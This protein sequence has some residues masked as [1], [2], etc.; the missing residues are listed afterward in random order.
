MNKRT[1][2]IEDCGRVFSGHNLCSMHLRRLKKHGTTDK[3]I[4]VRDAT[5]AVEDCEGGLYGHG[6]CQKHWRRWRK[7][8]T[9]ELPKRELIKDSPCSVEGCSKMNFAARL[10]SAHWTRKYRHGDPEARLRGEVR[11]GKRICSQCGIDTPLEKMGRK[12]ADSWCLACTASYHYGR[13][14]YKPKVT[15][16]GSCL[17]CGQ[18]FPTNKKKRLHC[19]SE[20]A[21][22]TI[23]SRNWKHL[24]RRRARLKGATTESFSRLEIFERDNWM[25]G[26]C[27]ESIDPQ[28]KLPNQMSASVDHIIPIAGGGSHERANV[29]AAHLRCNVLKGDRMPT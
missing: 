5:C 7:Y 26:L 8:G 9:P 24:Q 22:A 1:C 16:V 25:C 6:W 10:C 28:A 27:G 29:Q 15:G 11:D 4:P 3:I 2:S 12:G 20:C 17:A 21:E 18:P 19:S 23:H 13:Q 14:P